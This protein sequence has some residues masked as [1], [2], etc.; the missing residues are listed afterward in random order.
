MI[1]RTPLKRVSA[2]HGKRLREYAKLRKQILGAH[3]KCFACKVRLASEVHH[4]EG[5]GINT[6]KEESLRPVCGPCHTWIHE[7]PNQAR[8]AGYLK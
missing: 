6:A 2:K 5:R 7:N 4:F 3:P 1:R 8:K